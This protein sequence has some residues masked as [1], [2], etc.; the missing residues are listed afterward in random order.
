MNQTLI[1]KVRSE[2]SLIFK[3]KLLDLSNKKMPNGP[4]SNC[5]NAALKNS[6]NCQP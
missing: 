4:K 5:E 6:K 2:K 1:D 3:A